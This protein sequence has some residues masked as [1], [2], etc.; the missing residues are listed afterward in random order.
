MSFINLFKNSNYTLEC[1]FITNKYVLLQTYINQYSVRSKYI[2][3]EA[4][5]K[6]VILF[7]ANLGCR[8]VCVYL[9]YEVQFPFRY[10]VLE[11]LAIIN[12]DE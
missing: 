7:H 6:L 10:G 2:D 9:Q 1:P 4:K 8:F 5:Q 12:N 11:I 3:Q